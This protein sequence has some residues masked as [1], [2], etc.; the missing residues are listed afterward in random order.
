M[1]KL[2]IQADTN[3]N[4]IESEFSSPYAH[5][6]QKIEHSATNGKVG[7]ATPLVGTTK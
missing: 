5:L 3:L 1:M 6:A 7:G 4:Q 2:G